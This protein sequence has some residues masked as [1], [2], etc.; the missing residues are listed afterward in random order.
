MLYIT[1]KHALNISCALKTCGDWHQSALRWEDIT[2]RDS[3]KS[4]FGEYGIEQNKKVPNRKERFS[5]ANHI[6]ACLDLLEIGNFA[7]V[8]GMNNDYICN[9]EY[10]G[11]VFKNVMRLKNVTHWKQIDLFMGREYLCKWLDFKEEM[12]L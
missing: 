5:V 11:E 2:T 12:R 10:D 1:G 7:V 3:R 9:D 6:R 8:Q 4:I